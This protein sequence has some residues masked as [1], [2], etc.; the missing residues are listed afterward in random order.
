MTDT[1]DSRRRAQLLARM[2]GNIACGICL[3]FDY[4][5]GSICDLPNDKVALKS[6]EI[7]ERILKEVGL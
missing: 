5:S 7:A 4:A 1:P 6:L 3:G 2:A